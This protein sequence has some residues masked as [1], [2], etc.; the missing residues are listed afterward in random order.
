MEKL[1][2]RLNALLKARNGGN[3]S[4]LARYVGVSPQ[5]V[6]KW[7]SGEAEPRRQH[8]DV[9]A[10]F[11]GVTPSTLLYGAEP[12]DPPQH[13][14]RGVVPWHPD[15]P[16]PDDLVLIP[17]STIEFAAGNG[18]EA[19]YEIVEQNC[20]A[21]YRLS[22]LRHEG[23]NPKRARRF[24]VSGESQEPFLFDKDI[25]LVNLD[26]TEIIDGKLYAIRYDNDLR[27]KF[28]FKRLDGTLVLHSM[29]SAYPDEQVPPDLVDQHI[30]IIGRVRDKSGKGG[31]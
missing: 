30:S 26:E 4:E 25:V 29:N 21:T 8:I 5:A 2:T 9:I 18:R 23:I 16:L 1:S 7:L 15:D 24:R 31:L 13:H 11:L 17:E 28:L 12:N 27:V 10:Q 22:W 3:R 6:L 14:D 19:T 20:P